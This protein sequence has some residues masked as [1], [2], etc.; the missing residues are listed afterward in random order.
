MKFTKLNKLDMVEIH[1][2]H[3]FEH[4][5]QNQKSCYNQTLVQLMKIGI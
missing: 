2:N 4:V 3:G 5:Q 1:V